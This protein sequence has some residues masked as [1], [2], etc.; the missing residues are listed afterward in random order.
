MVWLETGGPEKKVRESITKAL[1][2]YRLIIGR[3]A[4]CIMSIFC[5]GAGLAQ[6]YRPINNK[7]S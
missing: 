2:D 3:M 7:G 5:S 4:V 6:P 1:H